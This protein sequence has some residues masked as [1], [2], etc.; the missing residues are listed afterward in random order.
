MPRKS[1]EIDTM[2]SRIDE[3][4]DVW[5]RENKNPNKRKSHVYTMMKIRFIIKDGKKS[6]KQEE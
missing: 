4:F 3:W 1:D 6:G 5:K 2:L